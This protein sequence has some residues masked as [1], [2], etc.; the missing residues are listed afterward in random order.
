MKPKLTNKKTGKTRG[1]DSTFMLRYL[2]SLIFGWA[3]ATILILASGFVVNG[4]IVGSE[5]GSHR[6]A[7]PFV[8]LLATLIVLGAIH[9]GLAFSVGGKTEMESKTEK[10]TGVLNNIYSIGLVAMAA[11]FAIVVLFPLI[12]ALTG[13]TS[14]DGEDTTRLVAIGLIAVILL[15]AMT[16][17]Q[18]RL[19]T[20]TSRWT[21]PVVAG[22]VSLIILVLFLAVPVKEARNAMKDRLII[23]DLELIHREIDHYVGENGRMP[24]SLAVLDLSNLKRAVGEFELKPDY[25]SGGSFL[26]FTLCTDGFKRDVSSSRFKWGYESF[27]KH[28]SGYNCFELNAY[29]KTGYYDYSYEPDYDEGDGQTCDGGCSEWDGEEY[30]G[31]CEWAAEGECDG[32]CGLE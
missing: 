20:K 27:G 22:A 7:E 32:T 25:G 29:F 30:D 21:Y 11:G 10:I 23:D 17:Y 14:L 12:G 15:S 18:T 8:L 2:L 19:R 26:Y 31:E 24:E 3:F 6:L 5:N 4:L 28:K 9:I 1:G 13:L 16:I